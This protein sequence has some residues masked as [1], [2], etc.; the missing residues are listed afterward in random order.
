MSKKQSEIFIFIFILG[1]L[2]FPGC[3]YSTIHPVTPDV[4]KKVSYQQEI[5]IPIFDSK[6]V[7]CHAGN[8]PPNLTFVNSYNSLINGGY[9]DTLAPAQSSLYITMAP[10]GGMAD[11]CTPADA[12]IVLTWITQGA[13]NN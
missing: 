4:E 11:Y 7:N 5:Q 3:E 1:I 12:Q 2:V 6:C 8:T 9:I 10:G 13:K